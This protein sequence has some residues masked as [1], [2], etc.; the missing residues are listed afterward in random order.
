M[1]CNR[2][3]DT[4]AAALLM[5][6]TL[7]AACSGVPPAPEEVASME[8][9]TREL[10]AADQATVQRAVERA[11]LDLERG[12][13]EASLSAASDAL[14]MQP[15]N[16]LARAILGSALAAQAG[17]SQPPDVLQSQRAEG[18]LRLALRLA[19]R[20][21]EVV[22]RYVRFLLAEGHLSAAA[23]AAE[24]GLVHTP[25][26]RGLLLAAAESRYELGEERRALRHLE[27]LETVAPD[28]APSR[29]R[30]GICQL[31]LAESG[32]PD[33]TPTARLERAQ[34]CFDTYRDMAPTDQDGWLA[35]GQ[36]RVRLA[37]AGPGGQASQGLLNEALSI[38]VEGEARFGAQPE[39][40]YRVGW[41]YEAL[42]RPGPA[43]AGY[44]RALD[45]EPL[46]TPALLAL[47]GLLAAEDP[48]GTRGL[49][50]RALQSD[51][52]ASERR[53]VIR[54]L[55]RTGGPVPTGLAP[56]SSSSR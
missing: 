38:W 10:S 32:G 52:S 23:D 19:P 29:Y 16:P 47:A 8:L 14:E 54:W 20:H 1:R 21:P 18:A 4:Q 33:E 56:A 25:Q 27:L 39:F 3:P 46:Y 28:H 43:A 31:R 40:P 5:L 12:D 44:R 9:P 36:A 11:R 2:K 37:E 17:Q 41:C 26:D 35:A 15:R 30:L 42:G 50:L 13:L 22:V 6:L 7:A 49:L 55:D 48:V 34:E 45:V 24:A 51:I 53:M